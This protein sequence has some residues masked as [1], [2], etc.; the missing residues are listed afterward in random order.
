MLNVALWVAWAEGGGGGTSYTWQQKHFFAPEM[1]LADKRL[2]GA[3]SLCNFYYNET[4]LFRVGMKKPAARCTSTEI[5]QLSNSL[6]LI[7]CTCRHL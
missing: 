1:I 2:G 5:N 4:Y 6:S 7:T 3:K